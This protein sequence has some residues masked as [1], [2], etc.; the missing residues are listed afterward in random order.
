MSEAVAI[1]PARGGSQGVVRKNLQRVGGVPLVARAVAAAQQSPAIRRVVVTTDDADIA[2]V[3]AEW[4]AEIVERPAE[5]AADEASSEGALLHALDELERRKVDVGVLAFLQATSPFI[6]VVALTDAVH[7]VRS[8]RRD[9]VFSAVETYGFLWQKGAGGAAAAVNHDLEF[10]PRRQDREPHFLETGA[11]YVMRAAGFRAA[12]HRFFGSIGIA[13]VAPRTAIEI[14]T[15]DEL[16]LARAIAPLVDRAGAIGGDGPMR[17]DA[18][19]TDFDG[20][21][22]D[23]TVRVDQHG[24]ESVVVSRSDGM[25]VAL[26]RAAGIPVLILSTEAN[27]VVTARARKLGADVI[28]ASADKAA[29]L[30]EWADAHG[31][32]LSRIAY[33]GNDVNDLPCLDLVGW[34]VA[35]PDAHPLVLSAARCVLDRPGGAGA[36]RDLADRVL[37]G[38]DA[39]STSVLAPRPTTPQ[40]AS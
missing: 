2:A 36:V 17:V 40:E 12:R 31:I 24:V 30:Q 25:G 26:L 4:G 38:R 18:V 32:P 29:A 22:T 16:E 1:I 20:V 14:D 15:L 23:D 6:D 37:A 11:F 8:R 13:E 9:S 19:V 33:L 3:A 34:P 10:R 28:Q 5:L 21:H 27:P 35:V 7:L 39:A